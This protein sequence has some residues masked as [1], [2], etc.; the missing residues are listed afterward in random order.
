MFT[1]DKG[2]FKAFI[3]KIVKEPDMFTEWMK[4]IGVSVKNE[5]EKSVSSEECSQSLDENL[6]SDESSEREAVFDQTPSDSG[7]S[8]DNSDRSV[9]F[10][11]SPTDDSSDDEEERHINV[12]KSHL[13]P[14]S[15]HFYFADRLEKLKERRAAKEQM[16]M[17]TESVDQVEEV[18]SAAEE[19]VENEKVTKVE[20]VIEAEKIIEVEKI[21]EVIK[22]CSK[23]LE[24]CKD[25]AAKD[26]KLA[27][28]EKMKEQLLFNLN[29]MKESYDVLNRTV[30]GLQKTNSKRET[31]LTMMNA[32]M[33][34]K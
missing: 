29:Y 4:S 16:Q 3:A 30:T 15:F 6:Q 28:Y 31:A 5:D 18:K 8:D 20:K 32:T 11:Q 1:D 25:C 21:V 9:E 2:D 7:S 22:P 14:E 34:T 23:C 24:P 17:N 10:D 12:A 19:I 27:E 26:E 33:M 13:S